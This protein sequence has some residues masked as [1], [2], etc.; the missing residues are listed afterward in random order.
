MDGSAQVAFVIGFFAVFGLVWFAIW[1]FSKD[2]KIKRSLRKLRPTPIGQV[3]EGLVK[4]A[5]SVRPL[6]VLTAPL[7]GRACAYYEVLVE[8]RVSSGKSSH[9]RTIIREVEERDFLVED[10]TGRARVEMVAVEAAVTR[11]GHW[12]SGTFNDASSELEAFLQRHGQSSEG[13]IFNK[14]LRFREGVLEAGERV[15]ILGWAE[16]EID[17]EPGG[18][19]HGFRDAAS[20]VVL[21]ANGIQALRVSDDPTT[22]E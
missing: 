2:Q 10:G 1:W 7:S 21:R 19:G 16:R 9:W 5:G 4:I 11:D 6:D 22:L 8:Q 12:S 15:A 20:R 14:T 18:A 3:R 17:P 13:W